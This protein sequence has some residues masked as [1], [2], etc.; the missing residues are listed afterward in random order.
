[1]VIA[2]SLAVTS[3]WVL[4]GDSRSVGTISRVLI[5]Q[6]LMPPSDARVEGGKFIDLGHVE[7]W[8]VRDR[9]GKPFIR[10]LQR[11]KL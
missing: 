2:K 4:H 11:Q 1:M 9:K 10:L 3:G 6:V 7:D 5:A 8:L